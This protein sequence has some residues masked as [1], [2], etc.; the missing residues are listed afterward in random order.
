MISIV[1]STKNEEENIGRLIESL[2][3]QT[4][5]N[6]EFICVD[7]FSTDRTTEIVKQYGY[8][9]ISKGPERSVQRNEGIK[10]AKGEW[11]LW[12]DCDMSLLPETLET[13]VKLASEHSYDYLTIQEKIPE[14]SLFAKMR[15]FENKLLLKTV[16]SVPRFIK[17]SLFKE[18]NGFDE[19]M[20]GAEDW[21]MAK[22]LS[23]LSPRKGILYVSETRGIIH[24]EESVSYRRFLEKKKYY[25]AGCILYE[26]KW[27]SRDQDV[28]RQL[29]AIPRLWHIVSAPGNLQTILSRPVLFLYLL[30]V[31]ALPSLFTYKTSQ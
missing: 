7:N 19:S 21:D 27:G 25:T 23:Q 26:R 15:N 11:I 1:V 5:Q 13:C 14:V 3:A 31:K 9:V 30:L 10:R 12:L 28:R 2:K 24:H 6:F 17:S 29:H 4:Y 16:I 8:D 22:R 18:I 20:T